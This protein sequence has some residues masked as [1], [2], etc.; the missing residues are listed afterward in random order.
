MLTEGSRHMGKAKRALRE[1]KE[2]LDRLARKLTEAYLIYLDSPITA[3]EFVGNL[4]AVKFMALTE[5][6][7]GFEEAM[8][9]GDFDV[10]GDAPEWAREV[11]S[12]FL[13]GEGD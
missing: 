5:S 3:V 12:E 10:L 1:R 7:E 4:E 2:A 11:L 13:G 8:E 6:R 9:E